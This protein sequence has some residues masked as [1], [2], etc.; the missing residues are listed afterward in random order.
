MNKIKAFVYSYKNKHLL[1]MIT[2][3]K[4]STVNSIEIHVRD[5]HPLDRSKVFGE[6]QGVC[7]SHEFWDHNYGPIFFKTGEIAKSDQEYML[8]ISDDIIL[9][10]GW[11]LKVIDFINNHDVIVSGN[12]VANISNDGPFDLKLEELSTTGFTKTNFV[13]SKFIFAKTEIIKKLEYP[14]TVKYY[15]ENELLSISAYEKSIDVF[16]APSNLYQDLRNRI[17]ENIYTPFSLEHGYGDAIKKVKSSEWAKLFAIDTDKL[18]A[19]PYINDDPGY[20]MDKFE[21]E[22]QDIGGQR[23][24]YGLKAIY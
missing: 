13:D 1:D 2:S 10:E 22:D 4:E 12:Y 5:Q 7:Y 3:L 16:A 24:T 14:N 19:I 8:L 20:D 21:L 15:G 11:D 6:V 9:S 17:L 23:F 18:Q